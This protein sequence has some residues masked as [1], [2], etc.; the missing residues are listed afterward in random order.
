LGKKEKGIKMS[1]ENIRMLL[2]NVT[3]VL[4]EKDEVIARLIAERD[5]A[6]VLAATLRKE[7]EE[8]TK[9]IKTLTKFM[10]NYDL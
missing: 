5:Q 6:L 7:I 3:Q 8:A 9:R 1:K 10:N 2:E 4:D